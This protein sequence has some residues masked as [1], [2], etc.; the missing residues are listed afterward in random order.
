MEWVWGGRNIFGSRPWLETLWGQVIILSL[1]VR[2]PSFAC[3]IHKHWE[4]D[5]GVLQPPRC[6]LPRVTLGLLTQCL[7]RRCPLS[8]REFRPSDPSPV[9]KTE[10]RLLDI[11]TWLSWGSW[12]LSPSENEWKLILGRGCFLWGEFRHRP[13]ARSTC[14]FRKQTGPPLHPSLG[15]CPR[16]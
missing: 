4:K 1:T 10:W 6:G 9:R 7:V 16:D 14:A 13:L 12:V 8:S 11:P 5:G 3:P 15:D 2:S